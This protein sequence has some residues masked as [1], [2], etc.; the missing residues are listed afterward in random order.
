MDYN[1]DNL[2]NMMVTCKRFLEVGGFDVSGFK[3]FDKMSKRKFKKYTES[4]E[5]DRENELMR[6]LEEVSL[7]VTKRSSLSGIYSKLDNPK[8]KI[9]ILFFPDPT[10]KSV[11]LGK[12]GIR[13][14]LNL[15]RLT[16]CSEGVVISEKYMAPVASQELQRSNIENE[17]DEEI[18]NSIYYND[19]DFV[20]I[21]D[22][23][24]SSKVLRVLRT[25]EEISTFL[26]ENDVKLEHIPAFESNDPLVKFYRGKIG[27]IFE[28]IRPSTIDSNML[29]SELTYAQVIPSTKNND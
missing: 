18:V 22:H 12:D 14:F 27:N 26:A 8:Y 24:S 23:I 19:G 2:K 17:S 5:N 28:L 20:N 9:L 13:K 25:E 4:I 21:V 29:D 15:I 7:K 3:N 16:G 10:M 11:K 1:I 6:K